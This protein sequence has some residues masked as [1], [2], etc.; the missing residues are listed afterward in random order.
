MPAD[1][2]KNCVSVDM[3]AAGSHPAKYAMLSIGAC[4]VTDET[5][6]FY[7]ELKPDRESFQEHALGISGLSM[8]QLQQEGLDP[9]Q[10]LHAFAAW[11]EGNVPAKP[12]F[13]AFNA[14][15]DWMFINDY[16]H[17]YT[18][19][20]PF[21]HSAIDIKALYLGYAGGEW[22]DTTMDRVNARFG[23]DK[24]LSHHALEDARDQAALFLRI[25]THIEEISPKE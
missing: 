15:F 12:I 11:L 8:Q 1:W 3:E 22:I 24:S 19:S 10:A 6:A 7:V 23:L 14:P 18:G 5:Q 21:G 2:L 13:V 16:F 20:N 9:G 4:L 25:I 17:R